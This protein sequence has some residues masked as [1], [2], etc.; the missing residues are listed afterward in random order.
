MKYQESLKGSTA[1][2]VHRS[3]IKKAGA[4]FT[5]RRTPRK[6]KHR[7][8]MKDNLL[9]QPFSIQDSIIFTSWQTP[10]RFPDLE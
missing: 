2:H 3:W 10:V 6:V 4:N 8:S 5:E 7:R 1:K 9:S